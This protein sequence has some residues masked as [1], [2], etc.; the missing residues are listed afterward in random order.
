M[1]KKTK[2][3]RLNLYNFNADDESKNKQSKK[4]SKKRVIAKGKNIKNKEDKQENNKFDFNNEIVIGLPKIEEKNDT[5]IVPKKGKKKK[6]KNK[7]KQKFRENQEQKN[8]IQ[9]SKVSQE[10]IAQSKESQNKIAKNKVSRNNIVQNNVSKNKKQTSKKNKKTKKKVNI[11]ILKYSFLLFSV[12]AIVIIT[13][14]SPLFNIKEIIVTGNEKI[15]KDEIISL[16]QI[17][18]EENTYK[19][20]TKKVENRILEN[21]YIKSVEV[22]RSL[23]SGIILAVQE[24]KTTFMI[25]YGN[26]Y[27]YVNNQGYILE[28]SSG[29]LEV[30]ILQGVETAVEE[31]VAGNRLCNEDLKKLSTVNKIMEMAYNNEIANLITRIDMENSQNYKIVL[32]SEQKVAYLGDETELNTKILSI[33]AILEREKDVAGEIFVNGDMKNTNPVFRQNV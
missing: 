11:K 1:V 4:K 8:N 7:K 28:I 6:A 26:S 13:M 20:N 19:I 21:P 15:T 5:K 18:I 32:E 25:E 29:K 16:S 10:K 24:R 14:F 23:P 22:K 30:P 33:K 31:L 9:K 17:N 27:V 3:A 2:E 12:L